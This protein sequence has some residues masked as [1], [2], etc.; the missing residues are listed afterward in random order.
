MPPVLVGFR[1]GVIPEATKR[2]LEKKYPPT[3]QAHESIQSP[4]QKDI[5]SVGHQSSPGT[6]TPSSRPDEGLQTQRRTL[7]SRNVT[8]ET[9]DD[10]YVNF[11][12]YCNPTIP[13]DTDTS[14]LRKTFRSPP[15]SDGKL[16]STFTLFELIRK[17]EL[18]EIKTWAQLAI[19]LG[20]EPPA[21]DKGQSAQKVQQYA[22]R[23]KRWMHAMHVDAFFEFLLNK[24]HVY[25]AQV[26]SI[27]EPLSEF[28]RDGVV[29]E[30]DLALRALL[31]EIRPKRGRRKADDRDDADDGRSPAQRARL[32]SPT[33]SEDF[34]IARASLM[35][36]NGTP[37][38]ATS[39]FRQSFDERSIPWSA[40]EARGPLVTPW[41]WGP[42]ESLHTPATAYPQSAITPTTRNPLWPDPNEPQSA[43]TPNKSRSRRRHGPAVSSAWPSNGSTSTGK[44]RGRPPSNRSVTDGPF[45]TF[46]AN[47]ISKEIPSGYFQN[48][49]TPAATPTV[50]KPDIPQFFPIPPQLQPS[51]PP[52][53]GKPSRLQLQV[54]Q[55]QGGTVR[56]A[57]PPLPQPVPQ[58][59]QV[60]LNGESTSGLENDM[61]ISSQEVTSM[62]DYFVPPSHDSNNS[63]FV[64]VTFREME[65][66]DD[67]NIAALEGHLICEILGADWYDV[68]GMS[69]ER[70]SID[71]ANKIC[72]QV[73][74][75]LQDGSSSRETFLINLSALAGGPLN[76]RLRITRLKEHNAR[77]DYECYWK[78]KF[79]AIEG[80]FTVRAGVFN[81]PRLE[82]REEDPEGDEGIQWKQR[83]LDLQ[84]KI[85]ARD[86][87]VA[88]FKRGVLNALFNATAANCME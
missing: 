43:I 11:I 6:M 84:Q 27:H 77:T 1:D 87:I 15:R 18:K 16:F 29:P 48:G 4:A 42:G 69:V 71:E 22:V 3:N 79:G 20:V 34:M 62:M 57:T 72:K 85:R 54:P 41:R 30:E 8:N 82:T 75:N 80:N 26:P 55:R 67:T 7:P 25:W 28:G 60:L 12:F 64:N 78:M 74:R 2:L 38:T 23:L 49:N 31:P 21:Y 83:Y 24:P 5:S 68:N 65:D 81:D 19:D 56:L 70:C 37:A 88:Q 40:A 76:T 17:L 63:S 66:T 10:T 47:P 86:E 14:E 61:T 33:L 39:D 36:E 9:I 52:I 45:S 32:N 51:K 58:A 73:I 59:P 13:M 35:P 46:P 53:P 44:L 50:D